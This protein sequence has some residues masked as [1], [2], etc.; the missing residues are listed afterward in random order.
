M[1]YF[2]YMK[3]NNI[4]GQVLDGV[5]AGVDKVLGVVDGRVGKVLAV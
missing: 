4:V 3:I 2:N 5:G 1:A